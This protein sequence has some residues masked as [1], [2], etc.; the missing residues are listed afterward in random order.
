LKNISIL[1]S[2]GSIGTQALQ[3]VR[4]NPNLYKVDVLTAQNNA[5][6]LI[7][8]ALEFNP[9]MVVITCEDHYLKVK[10]ALPNVNVQCGEAAL[11]AAVQLP[12]TQFVLTAIMGSVGL[13]PTIAAI[14]A[15]KD[16]GL[17]NKET[18]V[19][20]GEMVMQLA[21]ENGVKIIPVD[22][23]HSAIFQCLVGEESN[24]IEK[25]FLT[26]SG[27]PF[28][29]KDLSFLSSVKKE[30]ALKHPN[31]VMGAK[32]TIDSASLMN[33]G[34]EAIEAKWL[35]GLAADQIEIVVHPQSI[36]HSMVQFTD[37]SIKAQM[38]LP[39]M[40]LPI[41][42]ALAYPQ[43]VSSNFERFNFLNYPAFTFLQ[44]DTK[45]FRNLDLAF[46]AMKKGGNMPCI[47]NAANEIVVD[48]FLKDKIGFLQ[49][50][51]VIEECMK[52]MTFI[53]QPTLNN[54]LETDQQT[55]IFASEIVT[56]QIL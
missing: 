36:I 54:Y 8:Q 16:I 48:A 18:L 4:A 41:H 10:K 12:Q 30:Q 52:K 19:V 26:A 23:E 47:I 20:A 55:R 45:S 56:T 5:D 46:T 51:E 9:E 28:L 15:K 21:K 39:D 29:G 31:W 22:S 17:A 43:R 42:Y 44:A 32:I 2:T 34:L 40:K 37:G 25:I 53:A 24:P 50:S 3:V 38:G 33:K 6:L 13:K 7:A 11:I 1:G 27:G 49:M 35:F 14:E